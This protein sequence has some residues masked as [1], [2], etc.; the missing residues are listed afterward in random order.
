MHLRGDAACHGPRVAL[1][2]PHL[3][4]RVL[5]AQIFED[6]QAVPDRQIAVEERG[7][8]SGRRVFEDL[9]L[10]FREP[11]AH[12][13]LLERQPQTPHG[14]PGAQAPARPGLVAD[15]EAVACGGHALAL[16]PMILFCAPRVAFA[17]R[18]PS[19]QAPFLPRTGPL[20]MTKAPSPDDAFL[21]AGS[22]GSEIPIW[23]VGK[24]A[25][26]IGGSARGAA[27]GLDRG[28]GL[29]GKRQADGAVARSAWGHRRRSLRPG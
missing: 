25:P 20:R 28:C 6:G 13:D 10:R 23:L 15:D 2:R 14:E 7:H 5:L 12:V 4:V 17:W 19:R 27:E 11:E 3:C 16:P 9:R 24:G 1:C 8:Q 26:G 21:A 29:Q 18:C 22:R